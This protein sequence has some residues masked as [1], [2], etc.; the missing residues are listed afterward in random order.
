[1][2]RALAGVE[3]RFGSWIG[4]TA[5]LVLTGCKGCVSL[6]PD[7]PDD[8]DLTE[9]TD[10]TVDS[11]VLDTE[12]TGPEPPCA[13]PEVEP[14]NSPD[15][16]NLL[17]LERW[18]C[19][20]FETTLDA[21]FWDFEHVED[22]WIALQVDAWRRGSRADVDLSLTSEDVDVG[23]SMQRW[24]DTPDVLIRFPARVGNYQA[25]LRQTVG[26]VVDPGQ[27]E[28]YFYQVR[29]S[30]TKPPLDWDVFE[31][32]NDS[33]ETAQLLVTGLTDA[34]FR[35]F[36]EVESSGD[37]DWYEVVLPAGRQTVTFDVQAHEFGSA[38]DFALERWREG[39]SR[40]SSRVVG[41]RLAFEDD[42]YLTYDS[43]EAERVFVRVVEENTEDGA[44]FWY[45][46]TVT[47][48][49]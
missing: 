45:V 15:Q 29:A 2:A 27:G 49:E 31:A 28:D 14:N 13:A 24:Q 46:L 5:L 19:G 8:P 10:D 37:Q 44:P 34:P 18:A 35:V 1:M 38:G 22:G 26:N 32:D 36:G 20:V 3:V 30:V 47:V 23:F 6:Q 21:D 12:D 43:F 25:L 40:P 7:G 48:E 42:P 41:G 11:D 9:E 33:L 39:N 4:T 16:A 17:P